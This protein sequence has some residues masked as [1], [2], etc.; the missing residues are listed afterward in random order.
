MSKTSRLTPLAIERAKAK[1]RDLWLSDDEV[2]RGGGRLVVRVSTA[3]TKLFYFRYSVAGTRKQ[4]PL[5]PFSPTPAEG[6]YTLD[7]AR[8]AF[9][10]FSELHRQPA[11]RDVAAHLKA[12]EEALLARQQAAEAEVLREK[13][14]AAQTSRYSLRALCDWY[15]KHLQDAGKA[16]HANVKSVFRCHVDETEW[17]DKPAEAFTAKHASALIRKVVEGGKGRTAGKLRSM[18]HSAFALAMKA[19][20]DPSAPAELMLFGIENNPIAA[21]AALSKFNRP[22]DRVLTP[23]ELGEVWRRLS[24]LS[25]ASPLAAWAL[26]LTMLLGGQRAQ[27]LLRVRVEH[28]DLEAETITLFDP[29]GRRQLPR[30]HALPLAG[31]AKSDVLYLLARCAALP[32]QHLFGS[33]GSVLGSENLSHLVRA[34]SDELIAEQISTHPFQFR[35]MRRTAETMMASQGVSKDIRA[36]IQSH[37]LSGVQARHYDKYEYMAEKR[38]ALKSWEGYLALLEANALRPPPLPLPNG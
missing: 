10:R 25:D 9:R 33:R 20:L 38:Q 37:G 14:R 3:G 13:E 15:V 4:M 27:Q 6:R 36:Q 8:Q 32:S 31:A 23:A 29:K 26:R 22:R 5:R 21:T 19:E 24:A 12:E 17:A 2:T 34:L 30:A 7:Q 28:V 35:D 1:T 16:S 18:L 11:S